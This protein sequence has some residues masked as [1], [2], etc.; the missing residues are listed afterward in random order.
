MDKE[1]RKALKLGVKALVFQEVRL[2]RLNQVFTPE[3]V[4]NEMAQSIEE[5]KRE[6]IQ[7][8]RPLSSQERGTLLREL[9]QQA[10]DEEIERAIELRK[11]R[12]LR[13]LHGRF[14]DQ[15][16]ASYPHL[17]LDEGLIHAFGCDQLQP[18]LKKSCK[19]FKE[20]STA[21][22]L[23]DYLNELIFLYEFR[24]MIDQI[25]EIWKD[26]FLKP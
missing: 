19:R 10:V 18:A 4:R 22:T 14:Y 6:I 8:T 21:H 2:L 11:N 17:P 15:T 16:G 7:L 25:E 13:C 9:I 20:V 12:C 26:Y 5:T 24:E 1:L 23:E 3:V